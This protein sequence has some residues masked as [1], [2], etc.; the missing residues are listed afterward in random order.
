MALNV[1]DEGNDENVLRY[2][3]PK[4]SNINNA[5]FQLPH[6]SIKHAALLLRRSH[7]NMSKNISVS[8]SD[9]PS[10]AASGE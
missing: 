2:L 4:A 7:I 9:G 5:S 3:L 1:A 6:G 10:K 8:Y